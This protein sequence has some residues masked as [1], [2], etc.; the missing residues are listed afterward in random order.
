MTSAAAYYVITRAFDDLLAHLVIRFAKLTQAE[1]LARLEL[2]RERGE[3]A[4]QKVMELERDRLA[5][6][7][8]SDLAARVERIS[9]QNVSAG[10]DIRSFEKTER[11]RLIE[12]KSSVG[13]QISFEWSVGERAAASK[14]GD[15]YY[16]YFVP[17]SF[18]L[19]EL[20][21]PVVLLRNPIALIQSGRLVETPNGFQVTEVPATSPAKQ[22][23]APGS[24]AT[25]CLYR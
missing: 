22:H 20:T 13:S 15:A 3:L 4:E 16:I 1:L 7:N 23:S 19:P 2:Q 11:P 12:V 17:F 10:N 18:A 25:T 5:A 6:L 14:H 9:T 8:R 21:A 24:P